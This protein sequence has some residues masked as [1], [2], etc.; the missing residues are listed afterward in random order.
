[1]HFLG[2]IGKMRP[3]RKYYMA[4]F[5]G[6]ALALAGCSD[7]DK[8]AN[9]RFVG[10]SIK[11]S[12]AASKFDAADYVSAKAMCEEAKAE[13]DE[14][15]RQ[16]PESQVALMLVSRPDTQIG[17]CSFKVLAGDML[18]KLEL[19][20]APNTGEFSVAW[21][22]AASRPDAE[23]RQ[24]AFAAL[25]ECI[26]DK[27]ARGESNFF[28]DPKAAVAACMANVLNTSDRA[29]ITQK[30][31][32]LWGGKSEK[33]VLDNKRASAAKPLQRIKDE[34]AFLSQARTNAALVSYDLRAIDAL[35]KKADI[36]RSLSNPGEFLKVLDSAIKTSQNITMQNVRDLAM[37]RI[38][39]VYVKFGAVKEAIGIADKIKTQGPLVDIMGIV[40]KNIKNADDFD[41]AMRVGAK[42]ADA[43]AKD[44]FYASLAENATGAVGSKAINAALSVGDKN[45]RRAALLRL[46]ENSGD[47]SVFASAVS[48]ID[49]GGGDSW[50]AEYR[51]ADGKDGMDFVRNMEKFAELSNRLLKID[52]KLADKINRKVLTTEVPAS[53]SVKSRVELARVYLLAASNMVALGDEVGALNFLSGKLTKLNSSQDRMLALSIGD[54]FPRYVKIASSAYLKDKTVALKELK[55]CAEICRIMEARRGAE[56]LVRLAFSMQEN[57]IPREDIVYVLSKFLPKFGK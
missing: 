37:G 38:A 31:A 48:K 46:G 17:P 18:K 1:M 25:A 41:A 26:L 27:C 5:L 11:V 54:Y 12:E 35:D 56:N 51:G 7:P 19:Y 13:V 8:E 9:K 33:D 23:S 20:N 24:G 28:K 15:V 14:I 45:L 10:A 36:A 53:L 22:I 21:A 40:S 57:G 6:V 30:Y 55:E 42:I 44:A 52:A 47:D 50:M 4:F 29:R 43:A 32:K 34:A 39:A 3:M 2:D 16:Y 49:L